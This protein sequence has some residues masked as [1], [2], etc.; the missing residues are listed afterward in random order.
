MTSAR[1]LIGFHAV[2]ARLRSSTESVAEILLDESRED[3]RSRD[4]LA[5][6]KERGVKTMRV[7]QDRLHGLAG[8]TKHQGVIAMLREV[9]S[10]VTLEDLLDTLN[11]PPLLLV[12]DGVTDPRN[13][14]ACLRV[15]DAAGV[16]AVIVPRDK[17]AGIN[18]VASKVASGAAE[19]IPYYMVPNLARTLSDLKERNIWV[20][21]ADPESSAELHT[22][23]LPEAI[24]WV[25]G[26]EGAGMRRLTRERCDQLV[27]IPMR[28]TVQSLNV[29]VAAGICLFESVRRRSL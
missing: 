12:L 21:G 14:G 20:V 29:S 24:A 13:V 23:D 4:L 19:S 6:A 22:A 17:A 10:R 1:L 27:R 16:Q 18:A 15:A 2:M 7:N 26:G 8:S 28:G 11:G 3:A 9:V 5:L 25:L